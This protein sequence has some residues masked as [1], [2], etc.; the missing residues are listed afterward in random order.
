M[1][2]TFNWVG[3]VILVITFAFI[4]WCMR[5]NN[6][7]PRY[8]VVSMVNPDSTPQIEPRLCKVLTEDQYGVLHIDYTH[9]QNVGRENQ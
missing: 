4:G 9:P 3:L 6:R 7:A 5:G 1:N 2:D 8:L